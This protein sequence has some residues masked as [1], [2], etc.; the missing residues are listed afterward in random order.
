MNAIQ[1]WYL[2][3]D[4]GGSEE[5]LS[6]DAM[7][8]PDKVSVPGDQL[9][10]KARDVETLEKLVAESTQKTIRARAD[11]T[12][13]DDLVKSLRVEIIEK[14]AR[15]QFLET[16][17]LSMQADHQE[18]GEHL[19]QLQLSH[20]SLVRRYDLLMQR[21]PGQRDPM[22]CSAFPECFHNR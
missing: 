10:C 12:I 14:D 18:R 15:I 3:I 11:R 22:C 19:K 17:L 16:M 6:L 2:Y 8:G 13:A 7:G 9:W 5:F 21:R 1:R 20:D 4:A